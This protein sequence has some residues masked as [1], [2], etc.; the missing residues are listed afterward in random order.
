[1]CCH[2][3]PS[4]YFIFITQSLNKFCYRLSCHNASPVLSVLCLHHHPCHM[5]ASLRERP[6]CSEFSLYLLATCFSSSLGKIPIDGATFCALPS[7]VPY[8]IIYLLS[9][10]KGLD[11]LAF[12]SPLPP[13]LPT[14]G[15]EH[16]PSCFAL[17]FPVHAS[18]FSSD[19]TDHTR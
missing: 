11:A 5:P 17:P 15:S 3:W 4:W 12:A 16:I 13:S 18:V 10:L 6:R 9:D 8:C 2:I 14:L 19:V 7:D 1:M